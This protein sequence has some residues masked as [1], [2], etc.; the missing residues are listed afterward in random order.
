MAATA[1]SRARTRAF[2][3]VIGPYVAIATGILAV[4]LP[5]MG[6]LDFFGEPV[7]VWGVGAL[8]L[9]CGLVVI[10]HHSI[11]ST[12]PGVAISL[13][14]WFLALRGFVLM[15][16]PDLMQQGVEGSMAA[17]TVVRLFFAGM[18]GFGLWLTWVGYGSKAFAPVADAP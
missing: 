2:A 10:A 11:W 12:A 15:A 6:D 14:G 16:A 4:R 17:I 18:A 1:E 3:R 8:L 7:T 5:Q 13:F 9:F